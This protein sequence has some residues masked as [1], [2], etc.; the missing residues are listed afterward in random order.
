MKVKEILKCLDDI[1]KRDTLDK[2]KDEL[3]VIKEFALEL[4]ED[5]ETP[6]VYNED[7]MPYPEELKGQKN[8][9]AVF[10]D[11]ACRGNPGPGA[12]AFYIQKEEC[13]YDKKSGYLGRTTNNEMEL[14]GAIEALETLKEKLDSASEEVGNVCLYSDSKYVVNGIV[15]WVPRWK[16]KGWKKADNKAPENLDLWKRFD[17]IV[18]CYKK[19]SFKWVKGHSGHPQNEFCDSLANILLDECLG[20]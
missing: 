12:W 4:E 20:D 2:V 1:S 17:E 14:L 13:S 15:Q 10:S 18:S 16:M 9:F 19:I 6:F 8:S 3:K 7:Q 5:D 11:G